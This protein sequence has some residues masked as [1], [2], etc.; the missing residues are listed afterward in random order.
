LGFNAI[1]ELT[2]LKVEIYHN[3]RICGDWSL[4]AEASGKTCFH[5]ATQ[6]QFKMT[7]P[8]VG[9]W[10]LNEGDLAIFPRE[11]AH[12]LN[13]IER[14]EGEQQHLPIPLAQSHAGTSLICG[15]LHLQH[16]SSQLLLDLLPPVLIIH[17]DD[18]TAWLSNLKTMI[19]E[20]SLQ[21]MGTSNVIIDRLCELMFALALRHYSLNAVH[22]PG[23]LS[24]YTH[25][26]LN[27][28]VQAMHNSPETDWQLSELATH[29][30]MSRSKFAQ[31]FKSTSG[32]TP[33]QYLTWWRMQLAW[34]LLSL[35][36]SV[37]IVSE[38]VGYQSEAAFSRAF[39]KM[40]NES[41]GSVRRM[42]AISHAT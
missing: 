32:W 41:A 7:V 6:N 42:S 1:I 2:K 12:S 37:A 36:D 29:A 34:Q 13:P 10:V 17:R 5:M 18:S 25:T 27:K 39:S 16:P 24:L 4:S 14:L 22:E 30:S 31:S 9:E 19:L 11:L 8:S 33:F 38:K 15:K 40:F 28:A 20:E 3:A 26:Q 23:L 35:G 21:H